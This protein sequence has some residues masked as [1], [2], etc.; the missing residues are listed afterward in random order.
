M[1]LIPAI[2]NVIIEEIIRKHKGIPL[3]DS[4]NRKRTY[5]PAVTR[6]DE[7]TKVETGVGAAMAAGNQA[8]NGICALFV[9]LPITNNHSIGRAN[10][11][12]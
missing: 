5:T 4:L 1:A 3:R 9:I 7:C 6:V 10:N 12:K 11:P 8:A 2:N